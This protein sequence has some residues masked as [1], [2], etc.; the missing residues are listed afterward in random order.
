MLRSTFL[1]VALSGY[2]PAISS[3]DTISYIQYDI[4]RTIPANHVG[5]GLGRFS[6]LWTGHEP[7]KNGEQ[8]TEQGTHVN[9]DPKHTINPL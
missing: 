8:N 3:Y 2:V 9:L 4:V 6:V 1:G 5:G 7:K